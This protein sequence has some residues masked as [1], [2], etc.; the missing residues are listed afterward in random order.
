MA[1]FIARQ[2]KLGHLEPKSQLHIA[3]AG[4]LGQG[5]EGTPRLYNLLEIDRQFKCVQ[6]R[7]RA[8]RQAGGAFGPHAV[9]QT[10]DP[11]TG[12]SSYEIAL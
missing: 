11:N 3:G 4:S 12:R 7:M 2:Q 9:V 5:G 6:V 8:Q 1:I 10:S